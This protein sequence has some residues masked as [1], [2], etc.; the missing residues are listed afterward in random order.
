M[1]A[2]D[3]FNQMVI[4]LN[5]GDQS[6]EAVTLR[7]R[8]CLPG[9]DLY[10]PENLNHLVTMIEANP[11]CAKE[12]NLQGMLLHHAVSNMR[13][14]MLDK[15]CKGS[16]RLDMPGGYENFLTRLIA[17][18][19]DALSVMT[20]EKI[21]VI[22]C[23]VIV[24][25]QERVGTYEHYLNFRSPLPLLTFLLLAGMD[26]YCDNYLRDSIQRKFKE[27]SMG[28]LLEGSFYQPPETKLILAITRLFAQH[29]PVKAFTS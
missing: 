6:E 15:G 14:M 7:Q 4:I 24:T 5:V 19:K 21:S 12:K 11:D 9:V 25:G 13:V 23:A 29:R 18:N 10:S 28:L 8:L 22:G 2:R 1:K 16:H 17:L 26:E 3:L 27:F 20:E